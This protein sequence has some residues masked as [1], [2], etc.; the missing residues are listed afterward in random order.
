MPRDSTIVLPLVIVTA[1]VPDSRPL[2]A[3]LMSKVSIVEF[4]VTLVTA[5][6]I[7]CCEVCDVGVVGDLPG[8][9]ILSGDFKLL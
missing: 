8:I 6:S 7:G 5:K 2:T 4:F 3:I 1:Q 9:E